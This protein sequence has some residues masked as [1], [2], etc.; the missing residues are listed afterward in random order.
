MM[1]FKCGDCGRL[2]DIKS[3]LTISSTTMVQIEPCGNCEG[4]K[5]DKEMCDKF[6]ELKD[7]LQETTTQQALDIEGNDE[8]LQKV[9]KVSEK[10]GGLIEKEINKILEGEDNES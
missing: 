8:M 2:L 10:W 3:S 9:R 6:T 5:C 1:E 4:P 7:E